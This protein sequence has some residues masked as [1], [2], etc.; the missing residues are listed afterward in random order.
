MPKTGPWVRLA[1]VA[2]GWR[3]VWVKLA[4]VGQA[5][6]LGMRVPAGSLEKRSKR[7][8]F[9]RNPL[10]SFEKVS[11]SSVSELN[12]FNPCRGLALLYQIKASTYP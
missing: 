12:P 1:I 8:R 5:D 7:V 2:S 9:C 11:Y 3:A 4:A 10:V 6:V